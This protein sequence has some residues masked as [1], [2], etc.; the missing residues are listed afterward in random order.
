MKR[1]VFPVDENNISRAAD[2]LK[3]GKLVAL[4]TETVYGL[5]ADA[6]NGT[7]VSEI[8]VIKERPQFNPLIAHVSDVAM[9]R[10][11]VQVDP[12]SAKLMDHFWPGPLTIVLHLN[13]KSGVHPLVTAGLSTLA[14]RNPQGI[15]VDIIKTLNVP[16]AASSANRSGQKSP[17]T[18][19]AVADDLGTQVPFILDAGPCPVGVES[20]IIK[21]VRD[22]VLLLRPGGLTRTEIEKVI[23][24]PV[25]NLM[26][27]APGMLESYYAPDVVV[28]LDVTEV[29]EGEALLAFGPRRAIGF[30]KAVAILNLSP[31][32]NMKEAATCFF[33][34]LRKLD[35]VNADCIAVEPVPMAGLGETINDRL[36]RIALRTVG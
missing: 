23:A 12:L 6:T 26:M 2:Y 3:C 4:P 1:T 10:R 27:K 30:E 19:A 22:Q 21:I 24:Q 25:Q 31:S 7:A 33:D 18:A 28:R 29:H 11:Y 36:M 13:E 34:S 35:K 9:A 5:C 20:T 17:T 15:L 8:F 16:L 32:A 14:V